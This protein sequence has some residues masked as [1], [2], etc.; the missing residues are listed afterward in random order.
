[1]APDST[2]YFPL[3]YLEIV[4]TINPVNVK[5]RIIFDNQISI[6]KGKKRSQCQMSL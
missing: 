5:Y 3:S 2:S 1:M 6:S 4:S